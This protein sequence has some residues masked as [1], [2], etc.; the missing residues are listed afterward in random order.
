MA[1]VGDFP[2]TP[3]RIGL[4]GLGLIGGSVAA[5]V[6]E[7]WP[8]V[9][10]V[11][12]DLPAV[13]ADALQRGLIDEERDRI[14]QLTDCGLV[15]L[16]VPVPAVITLLTD[17]GAALDHAVVTDTGS[18]KTQIMRAAAGVRHFAG[19]HPIAG[20][21][22]GGLDR[23]RA[24]LLAGRPW[25]ITPGADPWAADVVERFVHSLGAQ[26]S[27]MDPQAHDRTMAYVSHLPQLLAVALMN[28]AGDAGAL[29]ADVSGA[30]FEDM[31]RLAAGPGPLWAGIIGSNGDAV[32][33][34]LDEFRRHLDA[35]AA[36]GTLPSSFDRA[37]ERRAALASRRRL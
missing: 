6:R 12:V 17:D 32:R 13:R 34:A 24:D 4:V 19:G 15:I 10:I 18:T 9:P 8:D 31:T 25:V 22:T 14:A 3:A 29:A 35:A 5:R 37:N 23:A 11:G 21:E 1:D 27:R 2:A 20:A 16:A 30:G 36:P 33:A 7:V 28:C 26:P